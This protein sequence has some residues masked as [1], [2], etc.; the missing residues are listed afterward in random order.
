MR[1]SQSSSGSSRCHRF[2]G[3]REVLVHADDRRVADEIVRQRPQEVLERRDVRPGATGE[4]AQHQLLPG[5]QLLGED[6]GHG[7]VGIGRL[8]LIEEAGVVGLVPGTPVADLDAGPVGRVVDAAHEGAVGVEIRR[9]LAVAARACTSAP[10]GSRAPPP[11]RAAPG[12]PPSRRTARRRACSRTAGTSGSK[13]PSGADGLVPDDDQ[14]V[15][16][17]IDLVERRPPAL[18]RGRVRRGQE[19]RVLLGDPE[20]QPTV[21]APAAREGERGD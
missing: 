13:R 9:R 12:P 17:G 20:C 10:R 2:S 15:V 3:I 7:D 18:E 19:R 4:L 11:P 6:A 5:P 8:G 14:P 16:A 21:I 1:W